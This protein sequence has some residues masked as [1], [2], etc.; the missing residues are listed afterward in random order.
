MKTFPFIAVILFVSLMLSVPLYAQWNNWSNPIALTN[1]ASDNKN[2]NMQYLNFIDN[3]FYIFWENSTDSLST[4]ILFK[5]FYSDEE[6]AILFSDEGVHYTNP[7]FMETAYGPGDEDSL[8]SIFYLS[9]ETG[10]NKMYYRVYDHPEGFT[11]PQAVTLSTEEQTNLHCINDGSI[12]WIEQNQLMFSQLDKATFTFSEPLVIDSG[13]ISFPSLV[14]TNGWWKK[15][16]SQTRLAWVRE[17]NDSASVWTIEYDSEDGWLSP[18][19]QFSARK[20]SHLSFCRGFDS[21]Y[22]LIWDYFN[23][24]S[25][26]F[27]HFD[28]EEGDL[29]ISEFDQQQSFQPSFFSSFIPVKS[30]YIEAGFTSI[31]YTKNDTVDIYNSDYFFEPAPDISYYENV[32][33]SNLLVRN[34]QLFYGKHESPCR[35]F[36]NNIWEEKA[37]DHWQLKYVETSVCLSGVAE[38]AETVNRQLKTSPNPFSEAVEISFILDRATAVE[39][40][41]YNANGKK[42]ETLVSEKLDVGK[43]LYKWSAKDSKAGLYFVSL[44][45]NSQN[46]TRKIIL[47]KK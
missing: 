36:I 32:S 21:P 19:K 16:Y 14:Y 27:V 29:Y 3:D 38:Q 9:D 5:K 41:I 35:D 17:E 33:N 44:Q 45:V 39:L 34:P 1:S 28:A 8:W 46:I 18:V 6:P 30:R 10:K 12:V 26:R 37:G 42:M 4:S 25:W 11:N 40:T 7:Q 20:C 23:D 47:T 31:V 2:P 15:R 24:T 43:H 22:I 13:N